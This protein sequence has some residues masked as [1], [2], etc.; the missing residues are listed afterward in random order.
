MIFAISGAVL[1]PFPSSSAAPL[2]GMLSSWVLSSLG[3]APGAPCSVPCTQDMALLGPPAASLGSAHQ[4][5]LVLQDRLVTVS[6]EG[7]NC[8]TATVGMLRMRAPSSA[9]YIK[10]TRTRHTCIEG[11]RERGLVKNQPGAICLFTQP[12]RRGRAHIPLKST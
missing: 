8:R 2:C 11:C 9:L 3:D 4:Q 12:H 1:L 5:H 10:E 6:Q 7:D